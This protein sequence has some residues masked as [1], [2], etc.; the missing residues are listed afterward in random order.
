MARGG[1]RGA[2]GGRRGAGAAW[3]AALLAAGV[4]GAVAGCGG[5][6]CP[7]RKCGRACKAVP[8]CGWAGPRGA[9]DAGCVPL[10]QFCPAFKKKKGCRKHKKKCSW[11]GSTCS[12]SGSPPT[13]NPADRACGPLSTK[14]PRVFG[15]NMWH[16]FHIM[17]QWLAIPGRDDMRK[18]CA[19]FVAALPMMVPDPLSGANLLDFIKGHPLAKDV[20]LTRDNL[21]TVM[22]DAQNHFSV[23]TAPGRKPWTPQDAENRYRYDVRG[24]T[25]CRHSGTW[26]G[27]GTLCKGWPNEIEWAPGILE[28]YKNASVAENN[29]I[30][31]TYANNEANTPMGGVSPYTPI[32]PGSGATDSG[33]GTSCG[34]GL[35][36]IEACAFN[37]WAGINMYPWQGL[38]K[39]AQAKLGPQDDKGSQQAYWC[40]TPDNPIPTVEATSFGPVL[41]PMVHQMALWYPED[42]RDD[43][44]AQCEKFIKAFPAMIPCGNCANDFLSFQ[45]RG[46]APPGFYP[47]NGVIPTGGLVKN[48]CSK[49]SNLFEFFVQAHNNVNRHTSPNR[50]PF[51]VAMAKLRHEAQDVCLHNAIWAGN[52][53]GKG[54]CRSKRDTGCIA[55]S[56]P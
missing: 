35:K 34:G 1:G 51:T 10:E 7:G 43:L 20:C 56:P 26:N 28:K 6:V 18:L 42:P 27:H 46:S 12:A 17:A 54:L 36:D 40:S 9:G 41:W 8:G 3:L 14:D 2:P 24:N 22:V 55:Y 39:P 15:P 21:I 37:Q 4:G 32:P 52:A 30:C 25:A 16:A 19:E 47:E 29:K 44:K 11:N 38:G 23:Y 31:Q 50:I 48:A 5:F 13:P 53:G 45:L 33:F 49:G